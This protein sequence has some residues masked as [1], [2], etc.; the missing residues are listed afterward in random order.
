V[1]WGAVVQQQRSEIII[2][3][4]GPAGSVLAWALARRGVSVLILDRASFPREKVCGDYVD[5][6]ALQA[7]AAMDCLARLKGGATAPIGRTATYVDWERHYD[8]PIPFYGTSGRLPAYGLGIPRERLDEE[9]LRV[10][11]RAGA[12]VHEQTEVEEISASARGVEALAHRGRR[13]ARYRARLI[14]GADGANSVVAR[15]LGLMPADPT[16]TVVAQRAYAVVEPGPKREHATEVFFDES[17]FPGYGWMF[18]APDGRVNVGIG[19]L[20]EAQRRRRTPLPSL[21]ES[22]LEGLRRNHPRCAELELCSKPIGGVVRTY[23]AAGRNCFDGGVLVG[24]AGSFADP[25]TGEGI[26]QGIES[27]LLA[28]PTLVAALES[29]AFSADR[30]S[31]YEADF[32]AY[33]DPSMSFLDLC[34]VMLRNHHLTRPWLQALAQGCQ[35]AAE[36]DSFARTTTNFFGGLD[37]R[38]LDIIGQ[39]WA[40]CMEDALLAWP[41]MLGLT[42]A[43]RGRQTTSPG[44]LIEWQAGLWRSALSDPR[45]HARWM[46]ELQQSWT[47]LLANVASARVDPR[48]H[49][50]LADAA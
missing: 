44:D 17:L 48:A 2:V 18:P 12:A 14:A 23:G 43:P 31:S 8:G 22:F 26:T 24:D 15:S 49:G 13:P 9:M 45:W 19:L 21:F 6:R 38:P 4:A 42:G 40:H 34:A 1:K 29:G 3:G 16:R 32:R 41:R 5:P 37:I 39:V 33:F 25:M 20:S 11:E 27:A 50:L 47:S 10:A 35:L 36:D 30:L 7:L 46:L 28:V